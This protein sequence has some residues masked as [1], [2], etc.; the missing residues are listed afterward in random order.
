MRKLTI[1]DIAFLFKMAL[2]GTDNQKDT[3][4]RLLALIYPKRQQSIQSG[5]K[6][7]QI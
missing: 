2:T 7:D 6:Y 1:N 5:V 3:A 4:T